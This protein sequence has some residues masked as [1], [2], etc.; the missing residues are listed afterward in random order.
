MSKLLELFKKL[1]PQYG[2]ERSEGEHRLI[3]E[4]TFSEPE[5]IVAFLNEVK[6]E[7]VTALPVWLRNLA[8]RL[9]TLQR[10]NDAQLLAEAG[11]D[12]LLFGDWDDIA[13]ELLARYEALKANR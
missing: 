4:L 6:A 11:S 9:A 12:L 7:D 1:A 5:E 3:E 13:N 8:Y 10:P 2:A